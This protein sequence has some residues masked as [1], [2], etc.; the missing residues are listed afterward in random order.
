M[1]KTAGTPYKLKKHSELRVL[2]SWFHA[3]HLAALLKR[4]LH[5]FIV[6]QMPTQNKIG[7]HVLFVPNLFQNSHIYLQYKTSEGGT[8]GGPHTSVSGLT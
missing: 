7:L 6:Y 3:P 5:Y 2:K 8:V 1:Y 4:M